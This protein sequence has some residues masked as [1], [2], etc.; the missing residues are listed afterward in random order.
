MATLSCVVVQPGLEPGT[1]RSPGQRLAIALKVRTLSARAQHC[2]V[3]QHS[4]PF[5]PRSARYP[6][7]TDPTGC[8]PDSQSRRAQPHQPLPLRLPADRA[9]RR[10]T[11]S[12]RGPVG[13]RS[14]L[15]SDTNVVVQPGLEP[16]TLRSPGQRLAITLKVRTLS[17][18]AQHCLVSQH[19]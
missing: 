12:H 10:T 16:G 3:S 9:Q 7:R 13:V 6:H 18:R 4:F 11:L 8:L 17:A 2:L 5:S 14:C 1:L 15:H 19:Q